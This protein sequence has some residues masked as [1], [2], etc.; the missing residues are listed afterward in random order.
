MNVRC[1]DGPVL[2]SKI[3]AMLAPRAPSEVAERT[4]EK[5]VPKRDR[6]EMNGVSVLLVEDNPVNQ[7]VGRKLLERIGC[8]VEVAANGV[9]ALARVESNSYT[10]VFM[11]CLMPEMDGYTATKEIRRRL[12]ASLPIIAMTAN[13]SV[14]D[15]EECLAAGM[16]D[17][18]AKPVR[19][20]ELE[21]I[22]ARWASGREEPPDSA[23]TALAA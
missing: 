23:S 18:L 12:G 7:Q 17:F 14:S 16:D 20:H 3:R 8:Q 13:V 5:R 4:P 1:M 10:M 21:S 6:A 19:P 15:R 9:E 22:V 11:D 2:P